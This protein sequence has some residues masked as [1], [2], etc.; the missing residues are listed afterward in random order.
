MAVT[1]DTSVDLP[2]NHYY[3]ALCMTVQIN[4]L[5]EVP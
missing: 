3:C 5:F 4:H 1:M 2:M